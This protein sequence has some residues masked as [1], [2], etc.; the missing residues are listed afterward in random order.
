[1]KKFL[2]ILALLTVVSGVSA[3]S[4]SL[5]RGVCWDEK[6]NRALTDA[7]LEK[8]QPG[9]SWIYTWGLT[10]V[11]NPIPSMLNCTPEGVEFIPQVWNSGNFNAQK[12]RDYLSKYPETR[13][14]MGYNEPNFKAQ[15]NMTPE[16]AANQWPEL[17]AVAA[18]YPGIKLVSP[19]LNFTGEQV[20]GRV[21]QPDAW[22]EEFIKVYKQKNGKLP[23]IDAIG[24]HCY[25]NW[26][27]AMKWFVTEYFY[28]DNNNAPHPYIQEMLADAMEKNGRYPGVMLSEF[29]SW[30]GD[31]DGFVTNKENQMDQMTQKLQILEQTDLCEGY[32]WFM[33]NSNYNQNPYMSLFETS[34]VN[35]ELSPLGVVYVYMS[36]FDK[37]KWYKAD[38]KILAKDYIDAP[39]DGERIQL[40]PD[41]EEGSAAKLQVSFKRAQNKGGQPFNAYAVYQLDMADQASGLTLHLNTTA[42]GKVS[43]AFDGGDATEYDIPSTDG[44][45]GDSKINCTIP[46]GK[47]SMTL[48]NLSAQNVL[49]NAL[50]VGEPSGVAAFDAAAQSQAIYTIDGVRV[51]EMNAPGIY[52]VKDAKG[53]RKV[54]K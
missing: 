47:H 16:A 22:L 1:M 38:E 3:Q 13:Y 8:L 14:I 35:S 25:M 7:P 50:C 29:C 31:K 32:A 40:R 17:E 26:S 46:A 34:N 27:G 41:T 18:D 37:E 49:V 30:E 43:I 24:L 54:L 9:V 10:P 28:K 11:A 5:K 48:T 53:A 39:I 4:R 42:A 52:I 23:R 33:A 6:G 20:G 21:W 45:W 19:A 2:L 12:L 15:A 51:S 44:K 36:S